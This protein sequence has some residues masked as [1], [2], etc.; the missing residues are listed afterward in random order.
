MSL[1]IFHYLPKDGIRVGLFAASLTLL[2][3]CAIENDIPYPLVEGAVETI[4]VEGQCDA[5]GNSSNQATINKQEQTVQLYVDDTVNLAKLRITKLGVTNDATVI[6]L[7][8]SQCLSRE[9]FPDKGFS[10]LNQLPDA[11]DTRMNFTQPVTMN[12]QTYQDHVWTIR[13]QQIVNREVVLE[14]Q[15]G[16]AT[17][18]PIN[19]KAVIYVTTDQP[20]DKIAVNSFNLGGPHGKVNPDPTETATY[21]FS[22]PCTFYVQHGWEEFSYQWEVFVYQ[23]EDNGDQEQ[24]VFPMSTQAHISGSTIPGKSLSVEYK[25]E[26]DTAWKPLESSHLKVDGTRYSATLPNLRPGTAYQYRTLTEGQA[27]SPV[28]FTT[29]QAPQLTDGSLDNWHQDGKLFNPWAASSTS[30]WDTGNRGATTISESNSVPTDDTCNGQGKAALLESKYLV[31]KFAAGNLFT[32]S[33]LKTTGTNGVLSF[34]R[35]FTA[36]PTKLKFHYKYHT[37]EITKIGE[38]KLSYLKGRPDSC[39]VYIALTDWDE[40]REIRTRPSERQLFDFNDPKIIAYAELIKGEN[41]DSYQEVVLPLEY[42]SLNRT[43]KFIAVI[44]TASKYGDYFTGGVGTKLWLDNFEL[45]YD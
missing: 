13:V 14:N 5:T 19:R 22:K 41:V 35:P 29:A 4:E 39:H 30:F 40:P 3:A 18:D 10:G 2:S 8:D 11:A 34:G 36:F 45:I 17:I 23:K 6:P 44:A 12:L 37:E 28:N 27:G 24:Q 21:D 20:L 15:I 9:N 43:P 32:G 7:N 25:R 33:Y 16:Q 1:N 26:K 42:R 38:D 31:M